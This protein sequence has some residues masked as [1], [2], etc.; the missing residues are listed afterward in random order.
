MFI[1]SN[2]ACVA[3]VCQHRS[4]LSCR[5]RL[6]NDASC[7]WADISLGSTSFDVIS[8]TR[9]LDKLG[10]PLFT[11]EALIYAKKQRSSFRLPEHAAPCV[12]SC[13]F[14]CLRQINLRMKLRRIFSLRNI[15][16][17]WTEMEH[18]T[19]QPFLEM[20][21]TALMTLSSC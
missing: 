20:K 4:D 6:M 9:S 7:S 16:P 10:C 21:D 2:L 12:C 14:L 11:A 8:S 19:V 15:S 18:Y 5:C 17:K 3:F 1:K 13:V